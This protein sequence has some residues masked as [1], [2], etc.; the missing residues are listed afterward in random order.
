MS[1]A[2][3]KR[4][5]NCSKIWKTLQFL[6]V[7]AITK[8]CRFFFC[9]SNYCLCYVII[10]HILPLSL[11]TLTHTHTNM[12]LLSWLEELKNK[13]LFVDFAPDDLANWTTDRHT[14]R[15]TYTPV[16]GCYSILWGSSCPVV[17]LNRESNRLSWLP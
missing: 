9:V 2:L 3:L 10:E 12:H 4:K 1:Q 11:S 17:C 14:H 5:T 16:I 6:H 8:H 15:H 7:E 13:C